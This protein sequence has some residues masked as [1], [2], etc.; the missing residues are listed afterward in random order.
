ML[1]KHPILPP[2]EHVESPLLHRLPLE[3]REMVYE[4][5]FRSI[6]LAPEREKLSHVHMRAR[7]HPDP[8]GRNPITKWYAQGPSWYM[9]REDFSRLFCVCRQVYDEAVR[10]YWRHRTLTLLV[11]ETGRL[12]EGF[13]LDCVTAIWSVRAYLLG[14]A[15]RHPTAFLDLEHVTVNLNNCD[16]GV[17]VIEIFEILE[18]TKKILSNWRRPEKSTLELYLRMNCVTPPF[19]CPHTSLFLPVHDREGWKREF[20]LRM[21]ILRKH[22]ESGSAHDNECQKR[23]DYIQWVGQ[24]VGCQFAYDCA[25]QA[26]CRCPLHRG[27]SFL[28]EREAA[29]R[30]AL[31]IGGRAAELEKATR[32][33]VSVRAALAAKFRNLRIVSKARRH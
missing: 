22:F 14:L 10:T 16:F 8:D 19:R 32:E 24:L 23:V 17:P 1:T 25:Q 11:G 20:R 3:L 29:H 13:M 27:R 2:L 33:M 26:G 28:A 12:G 7:L 21:R 5:Y 30:L 15:K 4:S 9:Y 6:S 18:G 31:N